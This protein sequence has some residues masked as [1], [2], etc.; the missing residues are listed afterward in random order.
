MKVASSFHPSLV[1]PGDY[2]RFASQAAW[3][4]GVDPG[5]TRGASHKDRSTSTPTTAGSTPMPSQ[6]NAKARVALPWNVRRAESDRR[7]SDRAGRPP[8]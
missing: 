7:L 3:S 4:N 8:V 5:P 2:A 6:F 1:G